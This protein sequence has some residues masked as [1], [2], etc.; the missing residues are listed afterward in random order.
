MSPKLSGILHPERRVQAAKWPLGLIHSR[1]HR[2]D[3]WEFASQVH[4]SF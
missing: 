2:L 1:L 4:T 3:G